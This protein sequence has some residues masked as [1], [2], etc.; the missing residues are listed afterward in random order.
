MAPRRKKKTQNDDDFELGDEGVTV[1]VKAVD[2][3]KHI[4]EAL[5]EGSIAPTNPV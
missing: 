1:K 4:D 5:A 3:V 2:N